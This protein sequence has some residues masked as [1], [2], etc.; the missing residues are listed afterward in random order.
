M[1][2]KYTKGKINT[3]KTCIAELRKARAG[4]DRGA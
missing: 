4:G 1:G 2:N 3:R